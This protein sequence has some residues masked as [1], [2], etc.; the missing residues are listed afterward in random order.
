MHDYEKDI[1]MGSS[2]YP[3]RLMSIYLGRRKIENLN[4]TLISARIVDHEFSV[5]STELP[6]NHNAQA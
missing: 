5:V 2:S 4:M 6:V 1:K 3:S